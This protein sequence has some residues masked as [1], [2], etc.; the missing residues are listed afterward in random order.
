VT[1]ELRVDRC[2]LLL[3]GRV[4]LVESRVK[5]EE[6]GGTGDAT[7]REPIIKGPSD[8]HGSIQRSFEF[9]DGHHHIV[10][11]PLA[12]LPL[13]GTDRHVDLSPHH[14]QGRGGGGGGADLVGHPGSMSEVAILAI[15]GV[16]L[17]EDGL[18]SS[19]HDVH[20]ARPVDAHQNVGVPQ[21]LQLIFEG[22]LGGVLDLPLHSA[23]EGRRR[24]G[25]GEVPGPLPWLPKRR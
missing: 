19:E 18:L 10:R 9:L 25:R 23:E 14:Q 6:A 3:A 24:G 4:E 13:C 20:E 22:H 1:R 21:E 12:G 8:P 16:D 17:D 15:G 2:A 7:L 11:A 5:S